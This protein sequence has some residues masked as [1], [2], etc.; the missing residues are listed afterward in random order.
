VA[1]WWTRFIPDFSGDLDLLNV[2]SI[3]T[4][5]AV[6]TATVTA[7]STASLLATTVT[8]P[9]STLPRL[10]DNV[11]FPT[12]V[13]PS[14]VTPTDIQ[15]TDDQEFLM[16]TAIPSSPPL[17]LETSTQQNGPSLHQEL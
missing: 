4:G 9:L 10:D 16:S 11:A 12:L 8:P 17:I 15:G 13:P 1:F 6:T 2:N 7:L 14:L 5:T 3:E